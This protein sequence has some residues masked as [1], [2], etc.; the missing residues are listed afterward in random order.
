M[1]IHINENP[2]LSET[3]ITINCQKTDES[4]VNIISLLKIFNKKITGIKEGE[5]FILDVQKILY[6]DTVDKKTFFYTSKDIYE[7]PLKLYELEE[8]L[9]ESDFFRASKS[10][11]INFKQIKSLRPEFGGKMLVTMNNDERLYVSRQY[12]HTIKEKLGL[13]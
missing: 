13:I 4:I 2:L 10:T 1:K 12:V 3:E 11:I 6:I 7:T 8:K 9:I 5:M